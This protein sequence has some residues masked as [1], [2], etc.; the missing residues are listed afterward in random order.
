M[1][2]GKLK[3]ILVWIM[4]PESDEYGAY[5]PTLGTKMIS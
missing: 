1:D 4:L 5:A 2:Q 3:K